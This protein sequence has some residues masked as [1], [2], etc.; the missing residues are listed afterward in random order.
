[1]IDTIED[2]LDYCLNKKKIAYNTYKSYENDLRKFKGFMFSIDISSVQDITKTNLNAYLISLERKNYSAATISRN[3]TSLK[4]YFHY[5]EKEHLIYENPAEE[6]I[7]PKME[8]KLPEVLSEEEVDMLLSMPDKESLKGMRDAAILELLYATGIKVSELVLLSIGDVNLKL[9]FVRCGEEEKERVIPFGSMAR[10]A[11]LGYLKEAREIM[12]D[13]EDNTR[14]FLNCRG[15][16]LSRQ[17]VWKMIKEYAHKAGIEKEITPHTL[18]HTFA[19][20]LIGNGADFKS[21]Q[22]MLGHS[23]ISTTQMYAGFQK[24]RLREVYTKNHPRG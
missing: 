16:S 3:I 1:M 4:S 19:A 14:L 7:L 11:L 2:F 22:E 18:R 13:S 15:G 23:D 10:T 17:G 24:N 12:A 8:K 6:L 9:N 20:H 5:L 21:V